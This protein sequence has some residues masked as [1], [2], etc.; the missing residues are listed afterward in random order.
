MFPVLG[1]CCLW[2][3]WKSWSKKVVVW[4]TCPVPYQSSLHDGLDVRVI[5]LWGNH[6]PCGQ[7]SSVSHCTFNCKLL[8]LNGARLGWLLTSKDIWDI[9]LI[10][11]DILSR[12]WTLL[13]KETMDM[14]EEDN[15]LIFGLEDGMIR[16]TKDEDIMDNNSFVSTTDSSSKCHSSLLFNY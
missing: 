6:W 5:R 15:D 10:S 4:P 2:C 16:T 14:I 8:F 3:P 13:E 9:W 1:F 12:K 7:A 11:T